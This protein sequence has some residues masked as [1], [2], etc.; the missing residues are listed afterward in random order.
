VQVAIRAGDSELSN[1]VLISGQAAKIEFAAD[2]ID[3]LILLYA[4]R[5]LERSVRA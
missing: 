2:V 4:K 3:K 1:E 5:D